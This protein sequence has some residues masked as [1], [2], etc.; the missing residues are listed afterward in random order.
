M[1][2][3]SDVK[4]EEK[5]TCAFKNDTRNLAKFKRRKNSD[6]ILTKSKRKFETSGSTRYSEKTLCYLG[7]E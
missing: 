1:T 6:F 3:K 5:L 2:L 4:F 7:N